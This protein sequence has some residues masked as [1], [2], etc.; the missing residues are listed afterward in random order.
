MEEARAVSE[1]RKRG[2][3]MHERPTERRERP[4]ADPVVSTEIVETARKARGI[5]RDTVI[6]RRPDGTEEVAEDTGW[7]PNKIVVGMTKLLAGLLKNDPTFNGGILFSAQGRGDP[8]FDVQLPTP[9]FSE[10][11]LRDEYFRKAPDSI[12]YLKDDGSPADPGEVTSRILIQTTFDFEEANGPSSTGEFI[13]EQG[14]YGGPATS[15]LDSGLLMNLIFH[16]A[17][18]KDNTVRIIRRIQLIL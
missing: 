10:T 15:A 7:R 16:K 5:W 2:G 8:I 13:R 3:D 18:F 17:R 14:L 12:A 9:S 11:A 4:A 1:L 6:R